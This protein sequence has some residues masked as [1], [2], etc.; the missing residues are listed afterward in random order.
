MLFGSKA[1]ASSKAW[2]ARSRKPALRKST[3]RLARAWARSARVRSGRARRAWW[4]WI[5]RSTWPVSRSRWLSDLEDL[6]RVVVLAGRPSRARV[7][8]SESWPDGE[9]VQALACSGRRCGSRAGRA[10]RGARRVGPG[11]ARDEAGQERPAATARRAA[12]VTGPR[13][14]RQTRPEGWR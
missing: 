11:A 3:P 6:D 2:S 9:V 12:S 4:I 14:S 13:R 7:I 5:A 1:S 10:G 8:A